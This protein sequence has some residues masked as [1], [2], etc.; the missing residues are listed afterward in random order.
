MNLFQLDKELGTDTTQLSRE[1]RRLNF[2]QFLFLYFVL[3][4]SKTE[5]CQELLQEL[6][7]KGAPEWA[8]T[9][10]QKKKDKKTDELMLNEMKGSRKSS[11]LPSYNSSMSNIPAQSH[12]GGDP[13]A[14]PLEAKSKEAL[15]SDLIQN[16][17]D[18]SFTQESATMKKT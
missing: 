16:Y 3:R 12:M 9:K 14:P 17:P 5:F 10:G 7:R 18:L 4:N 6:R 1:V 8:K 11:N 15:E 2:G 13:Q